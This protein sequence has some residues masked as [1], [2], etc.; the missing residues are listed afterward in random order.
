MKSL[1]FTLACAA[2]LA[3]TLAAADKPTPRQKARELLES[4]AEMAAATKPDVQPA[5]LYHLAENY[6]DFDKK[7]AIE[8]FRQ[9]F[10][11]AATPPVSPSPFAS[12][13]QVEVV[14][15]LAGMDSAEAIAMLKRM[16]P[17]ASGYDYRTF[18]ASRLIGTLVAKGQIQQ[19]LDLAEY[20][21]SSGAY[22]FDG[23]GLV[24]SKLPEGDERIPA[25]F[26]SALTAFTVKP[27]DGFYDALTRHWKQLPAGMAKTALDRVLSSILGRSSDQPY[28][29]RTLSSSKG[30][31]SFSTRL[32]ADLF[33]VAPLVRELDPK[34]YEELL[35][36][37]LELRSALQLFPGGGPSIQDERGV[38]IYTVGSDAKAGD[39]EAR[40]SADALNNRMK[41]AALIN[42]RVETALAALA[43]DP[44]KALDL[45]ADIPSPP[46]Q[47]IVIARIAQSV[48]ENDAT[49]AR[50]VL[51]RSI[52]MLEDIKYPEDRIAAWDAVA[53]VAVVIKDEPTLQRAIDHMLDDA[54]ALYKEDS[55]GD[56]PNRA[57]MENWPSTQAY[58]RAIFRAVKLLS[59]DA[60][61]LLE[62]I[63][64]TNQNVL[65]RIAM[66]QALLERDL[67][68]LQTYGGRRRPEQTSTGR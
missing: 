47:A 38:T 13:M 5:V 11:A 28:R 20:L 36:D 64:E 63:P 17:A 57:W 7:K 54:A 58:R 67:G 41:T 51:S 42:S 61:P 14:V 4:A 48:G 19:S 2:T 53:G 45:V 18:A 3:V 50:K 56:K 49:K 6:Q 22:P 16:E 24:L 35:A 31:A 23:I 29:T 66:A 55:D 8:F 25:V 65:A 40:R 21:G 9:A 30:N 12:S 60:T 26:S 46:Q 39:A 1:V 27:D 33:D 15:A 68:R 37:H 43:K 52:G 32:E 44:D 62:K 59:V 10:T 34:R